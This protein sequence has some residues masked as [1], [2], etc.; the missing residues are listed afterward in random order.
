MIATAVSH[1]KSRSLD[2][3]ARTDK[4]LQT[5][6]WGAMAGF[7]TKVGRLHVFSRGSHTDHQ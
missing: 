6:W 2:Y 4:Y 3:V 7:W 1:T 5:A